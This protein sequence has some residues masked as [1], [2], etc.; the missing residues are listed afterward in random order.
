MLGLEVLLR[1]Q[2]VLA[3]VPRRRPSVLAQAS[4]WKTEDAA[5]AEAT[6][7][8]AAEVAVAPMLL[9]LLQLCC[10]YCYR[11]CSFCALE[12]DRC[13]MQN[14]APAEWASEGCWAPALAKAQPISAAA[15]V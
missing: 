10:C 8:A 9:V 7:A 3:L 6:S 2:E 4:M 1:L 12:P 11:R 13:S 14:T 5:E 15:S